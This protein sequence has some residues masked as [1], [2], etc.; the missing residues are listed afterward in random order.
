MAAFKDLT[1]QAF[2]R[3]TALRCVGRDKHGNA[4][5][6]CKCSCDGKDVEAAEES[7]FVTGG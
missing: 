7:Q 6:L 3:L 2:S 1:N 5:W 4:V